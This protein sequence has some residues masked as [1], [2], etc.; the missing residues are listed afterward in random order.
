MSIIE[1]EENEYLPLS[2]SG[3]ICFERKKT[4]FCI[5]NKRLGFGT[6]REK[7]I[8]IQYL[9]PSCAMRASHE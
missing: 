5:E 8:S 6:F 1:V 4:I 9:I 2:F 3:F 7:Q